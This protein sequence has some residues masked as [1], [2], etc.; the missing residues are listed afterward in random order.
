MMSRT[1]EKDMPIGR[2]SKVILKMQTGV[3]CGDQEATGI[4]FNLA[5]RTGFE[6][7]KKGV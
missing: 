1:D 2:K 5:V 6:E 4:N 7:D 3:R